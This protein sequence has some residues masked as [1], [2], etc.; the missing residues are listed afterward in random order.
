LLNRSA[1][2]AA[3]LADKNRLLAEPTRCGGANCA[4]CIEMRDLGRTRRR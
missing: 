4:F 3:H 2:C 1:T